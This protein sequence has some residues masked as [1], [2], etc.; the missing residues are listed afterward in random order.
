MTN[1]AADSR[2][3][4]LTGVKPTGAP[5]IGNYFGAMRQ[6][7]ELQ[8]QYECLFMLPNLHSLNTVQDGAQLREFT[9]ELVIDFLT[10]GLDPK[11]TM[12]FLQ[13][14]VPAHAELCWIF[15]S[16]V[17]MPYLMRAH[18]FKDAE[19]KDKEINVGVFNYP[20]LMAADILLYDTKIVPV[21]QDQKQHIEMTRDI[22]QKFNHI[23][24]DT[25]ILP[26]A[27][28]MESVAVVPGIDGRKMSKSYNNHIPLFAERAEIAE[29]VMAIVTDSGSGIPQH[30]YNIHSLLKSKEELDALYTQHAGKYKALKEALIEDLEA[31]A[32][33][34]REKRKE[35]A[36]QEG[37]IESVLK[38]GAE[39]AREIA[40][41]K[42]ADV[43][44][45]TGLT[46]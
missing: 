6:F 15:D 29:K 41:A 42:M 23:Y 36:A 43:K 9:R 1:P 33:P 31:F 4:L 25:F 21:G 38:D 7:I 30:V 37:L 24:G 34:L 26:N 3:R 22:A 17:T 46:I 39:R 8:D 32:A 5:H 14:D 18:A 20:V 16:I 35:F 19:A 10:I 40:N 28:I 27:H 12:I 2:P 11:K 45:K 44:Q 13:S